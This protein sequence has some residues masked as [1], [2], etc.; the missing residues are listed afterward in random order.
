MDVQ[1]VALICTTVM[2]PHD[3]EMEDISNAFIY[4]VLGV[5]NMRFFNAQQIARE[6]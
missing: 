6:H 5:I 2:N 4:M 1:R 3:I